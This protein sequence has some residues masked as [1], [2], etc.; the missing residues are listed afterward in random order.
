MVLALNSNS[1]L[2]KKYQAISDDSINIMI[3]RTDGQSMKSPTQA[4]FDTAASN[5]G[6]TVVVTIQEVATG[7]QEKTITYTSNAA[8]SNTVTA[9]AVQD[10]LNADTDFSR[11]YTAYV[12]DADQDGSTEPKVY[13]RRKDGTNVDT[14]NFSVN[15]INSQTLVNTNQIVSEFNDLQVT[16]T[17]AQISE[18][19]QVLS[20]G[21]MNTNVGHDFGTLD[22]NRLTFRNGSSSVANGNNFFSLSVEGSPAI[23]ISIPSGEYTGTLLAAEM[24]K[25]ANAAFGDDKYMNLS[26]SYF[27]RQITISMQDSNGTYYNTNAPEGG[28][29]VTIDQYFD[30]TT[31]P[32]TPF[33]LDQMI[34]QV[35]DRVAD[36]GLPV[37][38]GYNKDTQALT[39]TSPTFSSTNPDFVRIKAVSSLG[40]VFGLSETASFA[41]DGQPFVGNQ[42]VPNG[43]SI[44]PP[45]HQ[46]SDILIEYDKE[47]RKFTF[48][49]GTDNATSTITVGV[50]DVSYATKKYPHPTNPASADVSSLDTVVG[51]TS[52]TFPTVDTLTAATCGELKAI[53]PGGAANIYSAVFDNNQETTLADLAADIQAG[54]DSILTVSVNAN[55]TGLIFT[56]LA[57]GTT[58]ARGSFSITAG[59][60]AAAE[61]PRDVIDT[62]AK[63]KNPPDSGVNGGIAVFTVPQVA[64]GGADPVVGVSTMN[65]SGLDLIKGDR[66]TIV[67]DGGVKTIKGSFD[68][69]LKT[70]IANLAAD[71]KL[72]TNTFSDV[73]VDG[74]IIT[75]HGGFD[76]TAMPTLAVSVD[77]S[78]LEDVGITQMPSGNYLSNSMAADPLLPLNVNHV[79]GIGETYDNE[80]QIIYNERIVETG[81][82]GGSPVVTANDVSVEETDVLSS[83][84]AMQAVRVLDDALAMI[85]SERS[86]LGAFQNRLEHA[87]SNMSNA[88]Q[89]TQAARS[90][91]ADADY[92]KEATD[93]AKNQ[94]LQQAGTAMLAQANSQA[95]TVLNLLK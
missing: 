65:L 1:Q 30:G 59:A 23:A 84:G 32:P 29:T 67:V 58:M 17:N 44:L 7:G 66:V 60:I 63:A 62:V 83:S 43:D 52:W 12:Y 92:A 38:V 90:V 26:A 71:L 21:F 36:A 31:T 35:Q 10:Y 69:D 76:G 9:V 34:R 33:T 39:F 11:I 93:L 6:D 3:R 85:S 22:E 91:I 46:R 79:L 45:W 47:A 40:N 74:Y 56:G 82:L 24:T 2:S 81:K 87:V 72:E 8:Q 48:S 20:G 4:K 53:F 25:Q 49:S 5:T 73:T 27:S 86:N 94:I 88:S 75:V 16:V 89:N 55:K 28:T 77:S 41:D 64:A 80:V 42:I 14:S 95:E 51:V 50:P 54:E 37:E 15:Q 19:R 18:P 70:T 57:D 68:T 78:T 13:I 61:T